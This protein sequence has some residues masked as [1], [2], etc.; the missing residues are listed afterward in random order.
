MRKTKLLS[1]LALLVMVCVVVT[2]AFAACKNN[3]SGEIKLSQTELNLVEG[4]NAQL[5]ATV[6]GSDEAISWS[7]EPADVVSLT[8]VTDKIY[9]VKALKVG[10]A[11]IT[12]KS[13]DLSATCAVTVSEK[14][15]VTITLNGQAVTTA[16]V[17]MGNTI[18]LAASSNKG[19]AITA[20]T[21]S[22]E[23]IATVAN[24][25][26]SGLKPGKVTISAQVTAS[27]KADIEVTVNSVGGYEYY[28]ISV[29]KPPEALS[30]T[31]GVWEC[32]TEW[33][34]FAALNYDNGTVNIDFTENGGAWYNIQLFHIDTAIDA[35]KFYKLTFD[36]D[37]S[38]AG[39]ITVN[40][41][42]VELLKGKHS[43]EV[44]FTNGNGFSIQFG[45][46][47]VGIDILE[48]KV[49]I[50]NIQYTEDTSRVTLNAPS[51]TYNSDTGVITINDSNSAGVKN[52][53]LNLYQNGKYV[54]GVTIAKSGDV[55]DWSLVISGTY[56]AKL[57]AIATNSH[58]IDSE[59]S[60]AVEIVVVNE[61]GIHYT[62]HN[63][64][65][66]GSEGNTEMDAGG[67]TAKQ[68][69]GIWTYWSS[70]WVTIDG[71]FKNDKLTVT[72]SNNT[73][74]WT[75]TQLFYKH[76]G[77][78]SGKIYK[79]QLE[80]D[81]NAGGRVTLNGAEFT[82]KEGKHVYD[83]VF[84]EN[85]GTSIALVFGLNGQ[86]TA[87]E[88]P[89]ATMVFE[90]K[91][92]T[93]VVA[94]K[95]AAPSFTLEADN[96]IKITD[97]NTTGVGRYELGF[98]QGGELK[99]TVVVVNN[100]SV[101]LSKVAAG[102]YQVKLRAI[103]ANAAYID[104]DWSTVADQI[105]SATENTPIANGEE[106]DAYTH[107]G[108]WYEWHDQ[109][110]NGSTVNVSKAYID[111]DG[112]INYSFNIVAGAN[113][114]DQAAHLY[115]HYSDKVVGS[116]YTLTLK[117]KSSVAC[118][119]DFCGVKK[120]L[121]VGD[122]DISVTFNQPAQGSSWNGKPIGATIRIY[123]NNSGEF[124]LSNINVSSATQTKLNAPSFTVD[125]S[126]KVIT[127]TDSNA[128]G[129]VGRY[130]LGFFQG[131]TLK[132]T[133]TVTNGQAV[134]LGTV[135][136][137][138]YTV[139]LKAIAANAEYI[140]SDW[141]TT[142]ATIVSATEKVEIGYHEEQDAFT[143][144]AYWDSKVSADWNQWTKA[145]CSKCEMDVNGK[146][147][148]SYTVEGTGAAWAMQMFYK[149]NVSANAY[150][151]SLKITAS[152]NTTIKVC[153]Q[154]VELKANEAKVVTVTGY[155]SEKG[156]AIDIQFGFTGGT[157]TIEDVNVTAA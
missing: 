69:P 85:G 82:I 43:Y 116:A 92:V 49:A 127:I 40:G 88:I 46:D 67:A 145:T 19:N 108:N 1:L 123:F 63:E 64:P 55:V 107:P 138:T 29:V 27:I 141:S 147:T 80:I 98:F 152:V 119:V 41:N 34:Q 68:T 78:E 126:S 151:S 5:T 23:N 130:E 104:S 131:E 90:I 58:Y 95:L 87:Q 86:D 2:V 113:T 36:I 125:S 56:Q 21:S 143:G 115:Y 59:E 70:W 155:K 28:E 110:W 124:V 105:T 77:L 140:D 45:V 129:S 148:M 11:T 65:P 114:Y 18:T 57:K 52:Y 8:R 156:S 75:D 134:A 44:Y 76:P 118:T 96:V 150:N 128:S 16:S 157:F 135:P 10:T 12:V 20:W 106:T 60:A 7:V 83:I 137:G 33:G 66:I 153:G 14:E 26:V 120:A 72:F 111:K 71:E 99:T 9:T 30:N 62:F 35:G 122:N 93:E 112:A 89:A 24:G 15:V 94:S 81:S 4:G 103:A 109:N 117:V 132:T 39:H 100:E 73:G 102:T 79:M 142:T 149:S 48:A 25:V 133:V 91:G 121:T 50:S 84:T 146:V 6:T 17:D 13:G 38:E 3:G 47:G 54:T 61:G 144:W 53:V 97:T 32:W 31:P 136:S 101:D 154:S 51:F 74:N 42:V 139:K 37:S 22:N